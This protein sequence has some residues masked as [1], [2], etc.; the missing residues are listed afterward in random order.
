MKVGMNVSFLQ[1]FCSRYPFLCFYHPIRRK[2]L[3]A[4]GSSLLLAWYLIPVVS[5]LHELNI[6][7]QTLFKYDVYR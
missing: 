7:T 6:N 5:L 1:I 3:H 2:Q 4:S